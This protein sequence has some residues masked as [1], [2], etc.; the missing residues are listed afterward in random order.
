MSEEQWL[1]LESE[2]ISCEPGGRQVEMCLHR[3]AIH[4][5][6]R[7]VRLASGAL[8]PITIDGKPY[9]QLGVLA[10]ADPSVTGGAVLVSRLYGSAPR[11]ARYQI[12]RVRLPESAR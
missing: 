4:D 5:I 11:T 7:H 10:V 3:L 9:T 2:W 8:A 6:D 12:S 1:T